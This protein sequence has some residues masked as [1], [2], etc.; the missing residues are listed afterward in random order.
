MPL[1]QRPPVN[2]SA[3]RH[4]LGNLLESYGGH[5][6]ILPRTP[7]VV[8]CMRDYINKCAAEVCDLERQESPGAR[9]GE[10]P[11]TRLEVSVPF[12]FFVGLC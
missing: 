6:E 7:C 1:Y 8:R 3:R 9:L 4:R 5:N 2:N 11:F 12:S 10:I